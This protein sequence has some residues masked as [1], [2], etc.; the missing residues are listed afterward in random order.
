MKEYSFFAMLSR[1]KYITRWGLMRNSRQETLSEHTLDV[2]YIAHALALLSG[3]DPA[4]AVLCA[5][6]H[7]CSEILTGDMPTPVKYYNP[8][9]KQTYKEI[10]QIASDRLL[11]TLPEELSAAYHL[12]FYEEDPQILQI[13]K[14]ADKLSALIK[15]IEEI[16]MGNDDFLSARQ[17]QLD[18]LHA[19]DLPAV[20][21]F[22]EQFLPAYEMTLDEL[23]LAKN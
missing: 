17:A 6:Y 22:L 7:D 14:A 21:T 15:C 11:S 1:M 18:A 12:C 23:N 9:I 5:L 16:R 10:E 19:M 20:E 3:L 8:K 4:K 2:A 13:V